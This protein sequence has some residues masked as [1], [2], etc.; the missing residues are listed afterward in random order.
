MIHPTAIIS[1]SAKLHDSVS[2]GPYSI[3]SD[4]VEIGEGTVI[5]PHAVV[6]GPTSIGRNNTIFQFVSLGEA[7][8]DK[9]YQGEPTRL[10]IGDNNTIR[11]FCT[12]NRGT[13][14]DGGVTRIGS[15]N[16]IMAY[17]HIAH[18]CHVGNNTILAN[19]AQLAGHVHIGDWA[20][21]GGMSAVHQYCSI[22]AHAFVAGGSIVLRDIPP[23]VTASGNSAE[24]RTVNIEGLRRRGFSAE[25]I[26]AIRRAYKTL[27]RSGL[28]LEDATAK[29]QVESQEHSELG[30][31]A[32]FISDS[33][34]SL[35]R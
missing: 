10:E 24:P 22:G 31:L 19:S 16:W 32:E 4:D 20:I 6:K 26:A 15:D 17:V 21:V 29:I 11:E 1:P 7:P 28:S 27:Y 12:L 23:Y 34:R 25:A 13:V 18:D 30:I 8:Q 3:I 14:Q 35:S 33:R 9:K 5:G 2:V